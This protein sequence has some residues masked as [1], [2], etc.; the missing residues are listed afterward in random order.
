MRVARRVRD[1][2]R[3]KGKSGL[4]ALFAGRRP[5]V[6]AAQASTVSRCPVR[7]S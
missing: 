7:T 1:E 3:A 5:W 4:K 2:P 6:G